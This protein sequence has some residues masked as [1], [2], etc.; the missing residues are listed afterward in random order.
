MGTGRT[1]SNGKFPGS[2][3]RIPLDG[4]EIEHYF[5]NGGGFNGT[6]V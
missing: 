1:P 3:K 6:V 2:Y 5:E 4:V